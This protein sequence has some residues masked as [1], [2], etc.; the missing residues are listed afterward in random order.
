MPRVKRLDERKAGKQSRRK[1]EEVSE[2]AR[3]KAE[4]A[5]EQAR[6]KAEEASE[7]ARRKAEEAS[8]QAGAAEELRERIEAYFDECD[9]CG[10]LY[11][12]AGLALALDM[13]FADLIAL[14]DDRGK[15]ALAREIRRAFLRMQNQI[16]TA[17]QY[18]EKGGMATRAIFALK[19]PW[20]GGYQDRSETKQDV[21]L[22]I[23]FGD[24]MDKSDFE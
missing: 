22:N 9:L 6:R 20:F 23:V 16:E 11:G 2:Q 4:E 10:Q 14:R 18:R 8:E 3:R 12:P 24:G 21:S 7:Q 5:S 1:A 15:P 13:D 17:P 19:Q